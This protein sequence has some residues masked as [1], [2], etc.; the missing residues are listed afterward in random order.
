[1]LRIFVVWIETN[2]NNRDQI[3]HIF[4]PSAAPYSSVTLVESQKVMIP[5]PF[6][7]R[8]VFCMFQL[9]K[10]GDQNL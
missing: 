7:V 9:K 10:E 6:F 4:Q 5:L 1:M 8:S 3:V 2:R